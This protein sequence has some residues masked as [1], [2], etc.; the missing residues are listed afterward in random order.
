MTDPT[1]TN[2]LGLDIDEDRARL[3][4]SI[5]TQVVEQAAARSAGLEAFTAMITLRIYVTTADHYRFVAFLYATES[6][7]AIDRNPCTCGE[8]SGETVRFML[9]ANDGAPLRDVSADEIPE[10][11][12]TVGRLINAAIANDPDTIAALL[13]SVPD[14]ALHDLVQHAF[15]YAIH[16]TRLAQTATR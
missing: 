4:A 9:P 15:A 7:D 6:A 1:T 2:N 13:R 5:A 16:F 10:P 3:V 12:R 8:C 11:T 14:D